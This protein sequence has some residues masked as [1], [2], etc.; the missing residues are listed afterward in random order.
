MYNQEFYRKTA[1]CCIYTV[2]ITN[3]LTS[4]HLSCESVVCLCTF[5]AES[6]ENDELWAHI[7][8]HYYHWVTQRNCTL[9]DNTDL[10]ALS[11]PLITPSVKLLFEQRWFFTS[12]LSLKR[13]F[14]FHQRTISC[15]ARWLTVWNKSAAVWFSFHQHVLQ[16]FIWSAGSLY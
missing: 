8:I 16:G 11:E 15:L 4:L 7:N 12:S 1:L 2:Y 5:P 10:P 3:W 14:S 13:W 6:L 9:I